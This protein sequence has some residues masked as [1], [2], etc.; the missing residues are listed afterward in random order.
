M[1]QRERVPEGTR[2]GMGS[3]QARSL[4]SSRYHLKIVSK[5]SLGGSVG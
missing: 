3:D 5:G 2:G 1:V 4:K